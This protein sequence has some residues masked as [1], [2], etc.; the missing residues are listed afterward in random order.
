MFEADWSAASDVKSLSSLV[1]GRGGALPFTP[2]TKRLVLDFDA[3]GIH[4]DNLEGLCFGPTL[5]NITRP[6]GPLVKVARN[7]SLSCL[8]CLNKVCPLPDHPCM[9]DLDDAVLWQDMTTLME[10][11]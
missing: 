10:S 3:L 8:Q 2:M 4:I 1:A 7:E 5:P 11:K 9:N 6:W